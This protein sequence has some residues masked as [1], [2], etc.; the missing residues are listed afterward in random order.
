M[1][2]SVSE[3]ITLVLGIVDYFGG[4][5]VVIAIIVICGG[6]VVIQRFTDKG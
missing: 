1:N 4:T 6:I 3:V 5:N 2:L